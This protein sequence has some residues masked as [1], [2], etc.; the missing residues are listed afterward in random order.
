MS[1]SF[2]VLG[3]LAASVYAGALSC[4][5]V[6]GD[7]QFLLHNPAAGDPDA[8]LRSFTADYWGALGAQAF[9]YYR[10]LTILTHYCDVSLYGF[11]PAGHHLTNLLLHVITTLLVYRLFIVLLP[12][13]YRPGLAGAILF[14]LHPAHTHTVTYVMGRTDLLASL[15]FLAGLLMLL[16]PRTGLLQPVS[17]AFFYLCALLCKEIA[18]TLPLVFLFL[19]LFRR[20]DG[21][22]T[23]RDIVPGLAALCGAG[24]LYLAARS[25]AVGLGPS[26]TELPPGAFSLWQRAALP[27]IT[28][29]FYA[30]KLLFPVNLCYYSNLTVPGSAAD[31]LMSHHWWAGCLTILAAVILVLKK[32]KS[33]FALGW[34]LITML[35]VLHLVPLPVLA[36]EN[37]LY[38][39]SVGFCLLFSCMA[40]GLRQGRL[41]TAGAV[42]FVCICLLYG[43]GTL[44]RNRDYRDPAVYLASTLRAMPAVS[45]E[46]RNDVRYFE[47]FKNHFTAYRNL[48]RLQQLRQQ[49]GPAAAAFEKA[50]E[51]LPAYLSPAYF[52]DTASSLGAVYMQLGRPDD[53]CRMLTQALPHSK[54]KHYNHNLLGIIAARRGDTAD[55]RRHFEA[56]LGHEPDYAPAQRNLTRLRRITRSP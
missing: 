36:K 49:P 46:H 4:D 34:M 5:F 8:A 24:V 13:D 42:A 9:V 25:A 55:A 43:A 37:Y 10:P 22:R 53:A 18:V 3:L 20:P 6:A 52:S 26:P 1:R 15:F 56:A 28:C 16:R 23:M 35:P 41:R 45:F 21:L 11:N 14:A 38:L 7:R 47:S 19:C 39:P 54:K 50:L 12:G 29:G 51:Y 31:I 17:A 44:R 33:G 32:N 30:L 27:L 40:A 2:V 48:G